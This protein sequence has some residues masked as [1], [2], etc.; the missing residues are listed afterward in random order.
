MRDHGYVVGENIELNIRHTEGV[1]SRAPALA[2]ELIALKPDVLVGVEEVAVAMKAKTSTIPIVLTAASDP[3]AAGLV[4]SL[5]RPGTNVTG[6]ANL[7]DELLAK[8]VEL[9]VDLVPKAKLIA[10]FADATYQDPERFE[11]IVRTAATAKGVS[12]I[13]LSVGN[14]DDLRRAFTALESRRPQGLVVLTTGIFGAHLDE[15]IRVAQR[16]RLPAIWGLAS[17]ADR[18]GLVSLGPNFLETFRYA[19][20]F[21]DRILKGTKPADLPVEQWGKFALVL[22][23]KKAKAIGLK[24]P[25]S[26]LLRADRVIE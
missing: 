23:L 13:V 1:K 4:Q 17:F 11:R 9:L 24:I 22:N 21:V 6:L 25:L 16:L 7:W 2:D 20:K 10:Y 18:G 14:L 3:V 5:A 12:V 8:H 19:A 15:I 26:V